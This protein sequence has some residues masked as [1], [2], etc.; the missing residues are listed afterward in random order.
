MAYI[1]FIWTDEIIAHLAEHGIS[2][3]DFEQVVCNPVSGGLSRSTGLPAVWGYTPAGRYI[4]AVYEQVD[5]LTVL[6]VTAYEVPE[7]R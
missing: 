3:D 7:P 2:Q 4:I 1:D 5:R 6:P